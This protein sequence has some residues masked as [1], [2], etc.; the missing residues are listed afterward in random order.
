MK[1]FAVQIPEYEGPLDFLLSI[2]RRNEILIT[3]LQIAPI[4][5]QYLAY[6]EAADALDVNLGMEW[7][8][9]AAKL[10]QW[11]SAS[12]LPSD[13]ALP[14]PEAELAKELRQELKSLSENELNQSREFLAN[15]HAKS[16]QTI[17]FSDKEERLGA[18]Q[19]APE[20]EEPASLWTL[21]KKAQALRDLFQRRIR[22]QAATYELL[23]DS[24]SV[25]QMVQEAKEE[26][27]TM[28]P[29]KWFS[30]GAWLAKMGTSE[31]KICLFLALLELSRSGILRIK[32]KDNEEEFLVKPLLSTT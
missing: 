20:T 9:M 21:R 28:E 2:V 29:E 16:L 14:D 6:I 24:L 4:A 32:Q 27:K 11:K 3:E 8:E 26:L 12:L 17:G 1:D 31:R 30:A 23:S 25:E 10:I 19:D 18:V 7:V 22:M 15:Q 13:P 5:A